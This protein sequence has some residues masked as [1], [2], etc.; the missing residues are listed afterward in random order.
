LLHGGHDQ[1]LEVASL[2][3]TCAHSVN[4]RTHTDTHT[5]THKHTCTQTHTHTHTNTHAHTRR[6]YADFRDVKD[7]KCTPIF[8]ELSG[9][10]PCM[11]STHTCDVLQAEGVYTQIYS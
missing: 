3:Y 5:H 10:A 8:G 9:L 7:P 2:I 1:L 4:L 6:T 11:I